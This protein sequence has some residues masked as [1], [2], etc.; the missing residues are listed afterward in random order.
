MTVTATSN[1]D[2]LAI[3]AHPDDVEVGAGGLMAKFNKLGLKTAIIDLSAGELATNGTPE[4]RG[5]EALQAA[6]VLGLSWRKCLN[7]PD[8]GLKTSRLTIDKLVQI[9]RESRPRLILCPYW[10]DRHPDHVQAARL[11]EESWF[12]AGLTK[13]QA[14]IKPYR[15]P[16]LWHYFLSRAGEPKF[17]VDVSDYYEIKREAILTHRSQFGRQASSQETF[18]NCGP[19][20]MLAIVESRDRFLGSSIGYSYGE[21]FTTRTPLAIDNPLGL[22]GVPR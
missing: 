21:G 18:L 9:I 17:I 20:S 7:L 12:D 10:E 13:I 16:Q 1:I 14:Q 6:Q 22:M 11:V 2:I 5:Q 8:R 3:G 19:G 4:I 15:P